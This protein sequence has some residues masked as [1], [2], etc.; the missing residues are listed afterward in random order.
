MVTSDPELLF[1]ANRW[2]RVREATGADGNTVRQLEQTERQEGTAAVRRKDV[3]W[4]SMVILRVAN[5][6]EVDD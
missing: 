1:D 6:R 2:K 3:E 4:R 5:S